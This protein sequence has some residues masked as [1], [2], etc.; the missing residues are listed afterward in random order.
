MKTKPYCGIL[1]TLFLMAL[2]FAV[3]CVT[4]SC[5]APESNLS[6]QSSP[7]ATQPVPSD[8]SPDSYALPAREFVS[9]VPMEVYLLRQ[10][11]YH[12]EHIGS[13]RSGKRVSIPAGRWW[14][15]EVD[16]SNLPKAVEEINTKSIPGLMID[17]S[18][19][20]DEDLACLRKLN[21]LQFLAIRGDALTDDALTHVRSLKGVHVFCLYLCDNI[22]DDGLANL[23]EWRDLNALYLEYNDCITGTGFAHL[24][25]L[26]HL[27]T[28]GLCACSV[29][30]E[31][32]DRIVELPALKR[33][34]LRVNET[35]KQGLTR[36]KQKRPDVVVGPCP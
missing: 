34:D 11:G 22:T 19:S 5:T 31:G 25:A 33:V 24:K 16:T 14:V 2:L 17:A 27:E 29:T 35:T 8:D 28:L 23:K 3:A 26:P 6:T 9:D 12:L 36:F 13:T 10:D 21:R 20:Q 4:S 1:S 18:R 32:L 15:V 7:A 30:D